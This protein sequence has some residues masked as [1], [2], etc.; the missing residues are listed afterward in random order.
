M[1]RIS[2]LLEAHFA[3]AKRKPEKI[4]AFFFEFASKAA[5]NFFAFDSSSAFQRCNFYS[6]KIISF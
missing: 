4:Q 6:Y 5:I 3:V 1:F 2:S